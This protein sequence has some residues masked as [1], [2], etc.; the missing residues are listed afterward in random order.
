MVKCMPRATKEA[1]REAVRIV[2]GCSDDMETDE[3]AWLQEFL[4]ACGR[5]LPTE[6]SVN[7]D[8]QRRKEKAK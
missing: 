4:A 8:A 3:Y 2:C 5:R 1:A 7:R 6:E